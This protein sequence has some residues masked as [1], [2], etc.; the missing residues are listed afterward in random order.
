ME[1]LY[2]WTIAYTSPFLNLP[3]QQP[4]GTR[5]VPL[6]IFR[7]SHPRPSASS[8]F[9]RSA[10]APHYAPVD[11]P[12]L[13]PSSKVLRLPKEP[14]KTNNR[15][16]HQHAA[17]HAHHRRHVPNQPTVRKTHRQRHPLNHQEPREEA[18][19]VEHGVGAGPGVNEVVGGGAAGGDEVGE[20]REDEGE[21]DEEGQVVVV[22]GGGEDDEEEADGEDLDGGL[23]SVGW[24]W[25]KCEWVGLG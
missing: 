22:E 1:V 3:H 19:E 6:N 24:I 9:T 20:G 11:F 17:H 16:I 13:L 21:C 25:E 5:L 2:L 7:S 10:W 18:P 15:P 23:V 4:A 8:C 12:S 14:R